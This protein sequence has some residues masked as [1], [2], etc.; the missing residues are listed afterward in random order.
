MFLVFQ[1]QGQAIVAEVPVA[2]GLQFFSESIDTFYWMGRS[3]PKPDIRLAEVL[4]SGAPLSTVRSRKFPNPEPLRERT[5]DITPGNVERE[6]WG[7][8]IE[9]SD[10]TIIV[11]CGS[12]REHV[13]QQLA[14]RIFEA[15][16]QAIKDCDRNGHHSRS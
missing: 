3:I 12:I 5:T 11:E 16:K 7:V 14:Q 10:N 15:V 9:M 1:E 6:R 13:S 2:D 8:R 4:I